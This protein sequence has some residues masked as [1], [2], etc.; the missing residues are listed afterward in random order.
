M[1]DRVRV[2]GTADGKPVGAD[3]SL[4]G[5]LVDSCVCADN[6]AVA[7]VWSRGKQGQLGVWDVATAR[8]RFEPIAL[9]G[10]PLS[11]AA[12][13]GSRQLAVICD[14]ANLLVIDDE[15]GKSM[16]ELRHNAWKLPGRAVQ[17]Q[18]SPDGKTLVSLSAGPPATINVRDAESG[19][20]RFAPLYSSVPGSN[21]HS[22]SLSAD[23]RF[24][25]TMALVK[26]AVQVWDLATG[27]PLSQPLPHPGDYW[28]L[29]SVRF[30][31]DGRY[32]LTG[33][34]DGQDRY[35]DWRAGKLVC[36]PMA[37]DNETHDVAITPDG[38]FALTV[39]SGRPEL[40]VWEWTT[41]RRVAPPVRV[42]SMDGSWCHTLA[43]T[44]DGRRALV[45]Y[46]E[47]AGLTESSLAVVD[48]EPLLSP[49]G[50]ATAD[51][52]LLSELATAHHIELGDLSGLTI[53]QW[54]ERWDL[55]HQRNPGLPASVDGTKQKPGP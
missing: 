38:R 39:I 18:Y 6:L 30:S 23:S 31:P 9:P 37:N 10:L 32:L 14:T 26:N 48:L 46:S 3:I 29:F 15:T 16:L 24:L 19:R 17:V 52:S 21:L 27:E 22:F 50:T 12:R 20:L 47:P 2:V 13:P 25:A 28:G 1:S 41:G 43:I 45:G 8:G 49:P 34:K 33:H 51:L 7:A 5:D 54:Q 55:L 35:W 44:P 11:V 40:Q 4:P 53:D 36:P 42:G